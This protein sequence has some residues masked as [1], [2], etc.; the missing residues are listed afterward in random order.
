L[1]GTLAFV[2]SKPLKP[3]RSS[4]SVKRRLDKLKRE[5]ARLEEEVLQLRAAVHIWT[6]VSNRAMKIT[7]DDNCAC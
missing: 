5:R 7:K 4:E 3:S 2:Q 6:E 1:H